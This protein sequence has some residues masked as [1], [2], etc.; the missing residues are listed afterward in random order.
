VL[1]SSVSTAFFSKL[2]AF[3]AISSNLT[4]TATAYFMKTV[5]CLV[6]FL[7]GSITLRAQPVL[8]PDTLWRFTIGRY[9]MSEP[10]IDNGVIYVGG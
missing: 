9:S 2:L 5:S 7:I 10:I 6:L 4:L 8:K 1:R 3:G